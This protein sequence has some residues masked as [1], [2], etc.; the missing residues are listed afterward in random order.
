MI[1][2]HSLLLKSKSGSESREKDAFIVSIRIKDPNCEMLLQ[3][4]KGEKCTMKPNIYHKYQ[5]VH[6]KKVLNIVKSL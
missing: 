1:E 5:K 2:F 3:V 6:Q 4:V